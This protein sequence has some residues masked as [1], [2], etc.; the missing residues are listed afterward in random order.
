MRVLTDRVTS[1]R[2]LTPLDPVAFS[3]FVDPGRIAVL[4][5]ALSEMGLPFTIEFE[6]EDSGGRIHLYRCAGPPSC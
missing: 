4:I 6:F 5:A 2:R 1:V 3:G